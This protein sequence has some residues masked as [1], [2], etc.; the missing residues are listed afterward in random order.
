MVLT[1]HRH[2]A[3]ESS[4]KTVRCY[5]KVHELRRAEHDEELEHKKTS[6]NT[7]AE[8]SGD[9]VS[10]VHCSIVVSCNSGYRPQGT[11]NRATTGLRP[12]CNLHNLCNRAATESYAAHNRVNTE[13]VPGAKAC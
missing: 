12:G 9:D 8:M 6:S 7:K 3:E 1:I 4:M 11:H 13:S 10:E 5:R 2:G